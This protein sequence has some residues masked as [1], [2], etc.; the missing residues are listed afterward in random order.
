M[1]NIR[2]LYRALV[3]HT[4][5][6]SFCV[7]A[8]AKLAG[9]LLRVVPLVFGQLTSSNVKVTWGYARNCVKL[10]KRQGPRGLALYLKACSIALQH[11]AGGMVDPSV[12]ALGA[13]VSRTRRGIPRIINPQHR[14]LIRLGDV[15]VTRFWLTLFGLYR[16]IEFDGRL[17]LKTITD[18]GVDLSGFRERWVQWIP[19]FYEKARLITGNSWK[20]VP[21]KDLA[22]MRIPLIQKSSPNSGGFTSVMGLLWDVLRLGMHPEMLGAF[23]EY[24]RLVDGEELIWGVRAVLKGLDLWISRKWDKD[25]LEL[26]EQLRSGMVPQGSSLERLLTWKYMEEP[27]L[28]PLIPY[29]GDA[30]IL[31]RSWYVA[32]YWGKPLWFGRLAF[33]KEPGKIR[34]VAMV[35]ILIQTLMAP[36]HKWIFAR[37]RLLPTDGTFNQV[38]PVERLIASFRKDGHWVASYDLSAATDRLPLQLQVDLLRPLLGDRLAD[39][40]AYLLVSQPYGLPRIAKSY[41][42]G[43]SMVWYAVGQPMGALSSWAL[44]A[45]THHAIVQMAAATVYPRELGWFLLYAVLGDDV[46][47]ADRLVAQEYLRIMKAIGVEISLAK[48]LV[49]N[50]SSLE[51][52]KRTWVRGR[53]CSPISLAEILVALRNLGSLG[54]LVAKNMKFGVIRISSVARF[55][56]FGYRNLARLPV[57]LG[58]GNRLSGVLAYL[59]RPGGVWPMSFEAWLGSVAPGG[60]DGSLV[61]TRIWATAQSVWST[62]IR[63]LHKRLDRVEM[64]L[65]DV[66]NWEMTKATFWAKPKGSPGAAEET[67]RLAATPVLGSRGPPPP[68]TRKSMVER[69]FWSEG[70]ADFFGLGLELESTDKGFLGPVLD[71]FV[72]E[73]ICYPHTIDLR[74]RFEIVD[75]T[76]RVLDPKSLPL[77]SSIEELWLEVVEADEGITSLPTQVEFVSRENE[78]LA[79]STRLITMW[80]RLRA[81][82]NRDTRPQV[83]VG[84]GF[85]ARTPPRWRRPGA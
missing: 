19:T 14:T 62:M 35:S 47:I 61:D 36:L 26:R 51:F 48:S 80:R 53:D 65:R 30:R 70:N 73:W 49:S 16:V 31:Y 45:L 78:V 33:L 21:H 9:L 20:V 23:N 67:T 41:N 17:K 76:L 77:W 13:A 12:W 18:P 57:A 15:A 3:P 46:V 50:S 25:F 56:G 64:M 60:A 22:P 24:L 69:A 38:K 11:S 2:A 7:K 27:F 66:T 39:L 1:K 85:S 42:L 55:C 58:L 6:W 75:Q 54:E 83:N 79:P 28:H 72:G 4:L 29:A 81:L 63:I 82:A 5:T 68:P 71:K 40:W 8:E 52:A 84:T 59:C 34:V 37:L 10:Y 74:R 32:F 43:Y 44:L